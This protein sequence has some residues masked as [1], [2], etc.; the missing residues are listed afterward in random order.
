MVYHL[1]KSNPG[2]EPPKFYGH[3]THCVQSW[4]PFLT[5][6]EPFCCKNQVDALNMK[7]QIKFMAVWF[8]SHRVDYSRKFL[9]Q[10]FLVKIEQ[11]VGEIILLWL[12]S[13]ASENDI[14]L[15][16]SYF[17]IFSAF[18]IFIATYLNLHLPKFTKSHCLLR[19]HRRHNS[20]WNKMFRAVRIIPC[21]VYGFILFRSTI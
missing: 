3:M 5:K 12:I 20:L 14:W 13:L 11:E 18:S 10:E 17:N 15:Q 7:R 21:N 4:N 16:T 1:F 9:K 6:A 19:F 2:N 8:C